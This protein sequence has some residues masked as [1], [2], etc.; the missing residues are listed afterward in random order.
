[1]YKDFCSLKL[2]EETIIEGKN[3]FYLT[4]NKEIFTED[5]EKFEPGSFVIKENNVFSNCGVNQDEDLISCCEVYAQLQQPVPLSF[6]ETE[7]NDEAKPVPLL[8]EQGPPGCNMNYPICSILYPRAPLPFLAN[9]PYS[10]AFKHLHGKCMKIV[11]IVIRK[12]GEKSNVNE[13]KEGVVYFMDDA[14][15]TSKKY[16]FIFDKQAEIT[17]QINE[18]S[19]W[20]YMI[21]EP[22]FGTVSKLPYEIGFVGAK[23]FSVEQEEYSKA[24]WDV[25]EDGLES[26]DQNGQLLLELKGLKNL[27][28]GC[29]R[30]T[31]SYRSKSNTLQSI[32]VAPKLAW[33]KPLMTTFKV[34]LNEESS[35]SL[36]KNKTGLKPN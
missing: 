12:I 11:D 24:V 22:K 30:A 34:F 4:N 36:Q 2:G 19:Y 16:P 13:V 10:V 14:Q 9:Y 28:N 20:K 27:S 32:R 35:E 17:I 3:N 29:Y 33:V 31:Y 15:V 18:E 7:E 1:M 6:P 5:E 25:F 21:I 8:I 26:K 23:G